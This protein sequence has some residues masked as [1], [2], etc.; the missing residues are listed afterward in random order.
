MEFKA[1]NAYSSFIIRKIRK[2]NNYCYGGEAAS[3][4]SIVENS[5]VDPA[6]HKEH[7]Y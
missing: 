5:A 2:E 1:K 3:K 4:Y 7:F 6:L